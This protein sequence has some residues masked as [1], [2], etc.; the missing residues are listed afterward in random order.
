MTSTAQPLPQYSVFAALLACAGLPIYIHA[1]KFYVDEFGL[2]LT[3]IGVALMGLRMLDFVQDPLLG[4]LADR[5]GSSKPTA[6]IVTC[7]A[8]ALAMVGLFATTPLTNP[9]MW[10]ILCLTVLFTSY[11]LLSILFYAQ[12]I[13]KAARLGESGHV[14][15]ATWREGGG[16]IGVCCA[17]IAPTVFVALGLIS[18][19]AA[20]SIAFAALAVLA[21]VVMRREWTDADLP[22][23]NIRALIQDPILRRL[24]V[25]GF[26]NAG[27]VAVTSTL[28]LY[29]VEYRIGSEAASGPLLLIFFLAAALFVP[30]WGALANR[31]GKKPVAILGMILAIVSFVFAMGLGDGDVVLFGL[32]CI[33]SGA[34]LGA[35]M[36]LLPALFA[37]RVE[38]IGKGSGQAFGLWAFSTKLTL[39]IAAVAVLP[40]LEAAG[41]RTGASNT[42]QV[43]FTLTLLYAALPCVLKLFALALLA[44]TNLEIA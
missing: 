6:V 13:E 1:P 43:L 7:A 11:S 30:V 14:T 22:Q 33:A 25:V 21:I 9:L 5:L 4:R 44:R 31:M 8:M 18:A 36:T 39:A 19:M 32:V 41:F 27:P 10:F 40:T 3:T 29:F 24:L 28:F 42:P 37:E 38:Q 23:S 15:V 26:L 16:L 17:A 35:D 20:F 34:A 12:G 2:S